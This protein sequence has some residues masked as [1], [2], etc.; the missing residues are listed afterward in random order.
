LEGDWWPGR[1]KKD[2]FKLQN[3]SVRPREMDDYYHR[4]VLVTR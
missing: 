4:V 2:G 3:V 1:L